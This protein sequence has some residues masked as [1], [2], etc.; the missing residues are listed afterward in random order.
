MLL[1]VLGVECSQPPVMDDK[2]ILGI[3]L[4]GRLRK[5]ERDGYNGLAV[6]NHD[7]V[8]GNGMGSVYF[9]GNPRIGEKVRRRVFFQGG[10][11]TLLLPWSPPPEKVSG[12][13][14]FFDSGQLSASLLSWIHATI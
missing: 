2:K 4:F 10:I 3:V 8:V 9:S 6:D 12:A 11:P 1:P 14:M 5:I 13:R 7:L